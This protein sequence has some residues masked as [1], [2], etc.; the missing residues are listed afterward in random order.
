VLPPHLCCPR[1]LSQVSAQHQEEAGDEGGAQQAAHITQAP[2]RACVW[3]GR[4]GGGQARFVG[5]EVYL[6]QCMTMGAGLHVEGGGWSAQE[7]EGD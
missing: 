2:Q 7:R 6:S 5:F 1:P 3:R 4:G